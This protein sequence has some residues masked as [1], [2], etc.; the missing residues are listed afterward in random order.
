M[1]HKK[2]TAQHIELLYNFVQNNGV[3][4]YDLQTELV[5]HLAND[6]ESQWEYNQN[7]DFEMALKAAYSGFSKDGFPYLV[8]LRKE[9]LGKRYAKLVTK[10]FI[11][12]FTPPA[13][14]ATIALFFAWYYLF[15]FDKQIFGMVF[16]AMQGAIFL[17]VFYQRNKIKKKAAA[18]GRKWLFEEIIHNS[19]FVLAY[20]G[21]AYQV[22]QFCF[23]K[24][25]PDYIT[26]AL[27]VV[28][29]L[30][31]LNNYIGVFMIPKK[32]DAYLKQTYP[33]YTPV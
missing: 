21:F 31:T 7:P 29:T 9:A 2:L 1:Q 22:T 5:D 18:S 12:F 25:T 24:Y 8:K 10:G 3:P 16:A 32:A 27:P 14:I 23:M 30:L 28:V 20:M 17:R 13:I 11:A 15:K 6:I 26:Y 4:Y 19:V 33:E